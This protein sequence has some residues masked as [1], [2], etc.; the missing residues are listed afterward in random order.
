M[1]NLYKEEF[2]QAQQI[3]AGIE[4]ELF[5]VNYD[6]ESFRFKNKEVCII[7][8]PHRTSNGNYHIRVRDG[9]SSNKKLADDLMDKLYIESGYNC[10]FSKKWLKH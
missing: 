7:F 1:S 10:T 3:L 6:Y 9:G 2:A 8:Y 5:R 4:G